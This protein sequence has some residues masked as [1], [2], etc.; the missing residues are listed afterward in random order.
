M[1]FYN[2]VRLSFDI[3]WK[4]QFVQATT[5]FLQASQNPAEENAWIP[6]PNRAFSIGYADPQ[7]QKSFL[8]RLFLRRPFRDGGLLLEERPR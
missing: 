2:I 7:G 8:T 4:T 6:F 5:Q 3:P 1:A